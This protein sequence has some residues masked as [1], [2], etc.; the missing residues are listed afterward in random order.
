MVTVKLVD[1]VER[2]TN[3]SG[4]EI[5]GRNFSGYRCTAV[6]LCGIGPSI[7]FRRN[8]RDCPCR[9][10]LS[11]LIVKQTRN[12]PYRC[13]ILE[14]WRW[15]LAVNRIDSMQNSVCL[16]CYCR[17]LSTFVVKQKNTRVYRCRSFKERR[18]TW[19]ID[20]IDSGQVV[21]GKRIH[22]WRSGG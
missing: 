7:V 10:S 1:C 19:G 18:P 4:H 2:Q 11:L 8:F 12:W 13:R 9:P 3:E 22:I 17:S 15:G 20:P 6:E 14:V 16:S 21:A 5:L